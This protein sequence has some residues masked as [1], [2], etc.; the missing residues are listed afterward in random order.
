MQEEK[1]KTRLLAYSLLINLAGLLF[2]AA[3]LI[4]YGPIPA[5]AVFTI[6]VTVLLAGIYLKS[7]SSR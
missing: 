7:I 2:A 5:I 1:L 4:L 3:A 6:T